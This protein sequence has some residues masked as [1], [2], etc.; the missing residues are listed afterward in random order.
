MRRHWGIENQLHW[1][2]DMAFRE[3]EA[4]HRANHC[5]ANF[6]TLRHFAV[7]LLRLDT[8]KKVGIA[9]KRKNAGWSRNY[10]LHVL[11]GAYSA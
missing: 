4:R 5:A 3:D 9:N 2:L 10:L 11:S 6:A 1:V 7:D 8:T